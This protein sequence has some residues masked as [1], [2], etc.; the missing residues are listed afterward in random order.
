MGNH[1]VTNAARQ[2]HGRTAGAV[3]R[4]L[5]S[6][7]PE[8][9]A[10]SIWSGESSGVAAG[11]LRFKRQPVAINSARAI[12]LDDRP[13][14]FVLIVVE[15]TSRANDPRSVSIIKIGILHEDFPLLMNDALARNAG[16]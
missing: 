7:L 6:D 16:A 10:F 9:S 3:I 8:S 2:R 13:D 12:R 11:L 4:S 5:E 1:K 14:Q 15:R